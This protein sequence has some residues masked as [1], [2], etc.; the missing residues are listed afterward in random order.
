[1]GIL[2]EMKY[3]GI[4][5]DDSSTCMN[6]LSAVSVS[7]NFENGCYTDFNEETDGYIQKPKKGDSDLS[8]YYKA[9]CL[10]KQSCTI[11]IEYTQNKDK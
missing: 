9:N 1:M 11:P 5:K 6:L 10:N 7:E 3:I 8:K 4:S 2:Q